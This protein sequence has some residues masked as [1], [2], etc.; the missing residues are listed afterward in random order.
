MLEANNLVAMFGKKIGIDELIL[1]ESNSCTLTFDG[2]AIT[3]EY[4]EE[5]DTF[6]IYSKVADLPE[7][8]ERLAVYEFILEQNCFYKGTGGGALGIEKSFNSIIHTTL[9]PI[10]SASENAATRFDALI[11]MHVNTVEAMQSALKNL[12]IANEPE[13][14]ANDNLIN[15]AIRI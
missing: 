12:L 14:I 1:D 2:I 9:F 11:S 3:I 13:T 10:Q 5:K 6:Y 15:T 8:Q 4:L 7:E